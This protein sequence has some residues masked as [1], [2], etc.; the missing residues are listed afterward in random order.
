MRTTIRD[1]WNWRHWLSTT[2]TFIAVD[3]DVVD[4]GLPHTIHRAIVLP[5][6]LI[7]SFGDEPPPKDSVETLL[8]EKIHTLQKSHFPRFFHA[9]YRAWGWRRL[10][11]AEVPTMIT[12][13]HRTNPDTPE[14]WALEHAGS[15]WIPCAR[16]R[17]GARTLTEVDYFLVRVREG[18]ALEWEPME[19]AA[20][21]GAY[22]GHRS[23]C[24]HPDEN[25][26]VILAEWLAN[27][28]P[29][30]HHNDGD[31]A[32]RERCEADKRL[33]EIM[34]VASTAKT[35]QHGRPS[36]PIR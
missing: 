11:R 10:R 23:M 5:I 15:S 20:W 19:Q 2:W 18:H 27:D 34:Q 28:L 24:Y 33:L 4:S 22:Y 32:P 17:R 1:L 6:W 31:N 7:E 35:T 9:L 13:N 29:S 26:A 8:H 3:G 14:W 25:A 16:L 30:S 36:T 12:R 21:Y